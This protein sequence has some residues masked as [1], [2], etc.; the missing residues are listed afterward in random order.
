MARVHSPKAQ[1]DQA[2]Q[3][4]RENG[5]FIV[6]RGD[7][8]LLYR[9]TGVRPA[10]LGKCGTADALFRKVHRCAFKH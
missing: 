3:I 10:Y 7:A 9:S 6:R 8:Y 1:F 4:A 2:A 5:M